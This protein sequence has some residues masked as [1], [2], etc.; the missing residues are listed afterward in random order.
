MYVDSPPNDLVQVFPF[1]GSVII[2]V[3]KGI[4]DNWTFPTV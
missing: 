3:F 4:L 1:K 2:T